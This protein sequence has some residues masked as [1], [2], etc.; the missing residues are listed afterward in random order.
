MGVNSRLY[1][2]VMCAIFC[3]PALAYKEKSHGAMSQAAAFTAIDNSEILSVIR[4]LGFF[5]QEE[6]NFLPV[7]PGAKALYES[8]GA[9]DADFRSI[10]KIGAMNEDLT[11]EIINGKAVGQRPLHHFFNPQQ[12][13]STFSS[14]CGGLL[15]LLTAS[16]D[17]MFENS[18]KFG[19]NILP[20]VPVERQYF[21]YRD[22][23]RYQACAVLPRAGSECVVPGQGAVGQPNE[24]RRQ[25]AGYMFQ[26][27]G[28][29]VHHIQD[30]SQPQH[31]RGDPRR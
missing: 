16:P 1:L 2:F 5:S 10:I 25:N 18:G 30:M 17:W 21:S 6:A 20:G 26:S 4:D 9:V 23:R 22:A 7:S 11:S 15:N 28:H 14:V 13:C 19:A 24:I 27:L 29:L 3:V 12:S 8:S 31:V